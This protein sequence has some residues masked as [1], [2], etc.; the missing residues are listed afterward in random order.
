[1]PMTILVRSDQAHRSRERGVSVGARYRGCG[2][3]RRGVKFKFKILAK[4]RKSPIPS[5]SKPS[6]CKPWGRNQIVP[7][8]KRIWYNS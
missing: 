1:M 2:V 5:H 6:I 4:N 7:T 3:T 8:N